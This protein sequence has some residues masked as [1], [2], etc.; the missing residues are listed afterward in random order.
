[1]AIKFRDYY[2]ILG[3][4]RTASQDEIRTA[5]RKLARKYHPDVNKAKDAGDRFKELNEANEVLGDPQKRKKYDQL[6]ANWRMGDEFTPPPGWEH[7]GRGGAGAVGGSAFS[8]FFESLFGGKFG[9]FRDSRGFGGFSDFGQ[10]GGVV[11]EEQGQGADEEAHIEISLDDAFHG[12][13]RTIAVQ[14]PEGGPDGRVRTTT[15]HLRVKIPKGISTGQ[16]IRL[17]GQGAPGPG[18]RGDLYLVVELEPHADF[19]VEGRNLHTT[20]S[21]APWEAVLGAE[22]PLKTLAGGLT[23][24]IPPGTSSGA[25]MRLKGKGLP[26]PSGTP[27]DLYAEVKI[28]T[29]KRLTAAEKELWQKLSKES[30]FNPRS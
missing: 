23:L 15:R 26:N 30:K 3:V 24:T 9:G 11:E 22:I 12:T 29:P 25:K 18:G 2:E 19:R 1:M 16:R 6:G 21:V 17:A 5:Y 27:G 13:E 10:H 28:V 14:M 7:V 8:D 20:L 4:P